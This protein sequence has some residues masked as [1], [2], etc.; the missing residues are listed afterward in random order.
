MRAGIGIVL[1]VL[2]AAALIFLAD[3]FNRLGT[4]G[5][6]GFIEAGSKFGVKVGEARSEASSKLVRRGLR[7]GQP[8]S[9]GRCLGKDYPADQ[10]I[11]LF[12][13]HSWRQGVICLG[14]KSGTVTSIAWSYGGWQF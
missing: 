4:F 13:D 11:D 6:G 1:V 12:D 3:D 9:A 7:P 10:T 14:S 8:S 2:G 5:S